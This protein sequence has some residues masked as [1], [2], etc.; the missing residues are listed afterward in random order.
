LQRTDPLPPASEEAV[1]SAL[2]GLRRWI[3]SQS[4]KGYDP[5]DGLNAAVPFGTF[6]KWPAIL[7]MQFLKRFPLN[8]RP[9]LGIRK[10]YNPKAMGLLLHAYSLLYSADQSPATMATMDFLFNWLRANRSKGFSGYAWGYNFDWAGKA[11]TVKA[12][13]P[14]AVVTGFVARGLRAYRQATG[15]RAADELLAG[16]AEFVLR[17]LHHRPIEGGR[18]ISYTPLAMDYC[19]NASLLG[20]EVLASAWPVTGDAAC[21]AAAREAVD[22]VCGRQKPSGRWN[23]SWD[24]TTGRERGQ[25]DFHQGYIIESIHEIGRLLQW[26]EPAHA[27]A[28]KRGL[29]YYYTEQFFRDGRS[30]WRLPVEW[31][32]EIHNQAQGIITFSRLASFDAAYRPFAGVIA[33]WTIRNMQS[34]GGY[35]YYRKYRAFTNRIPYMRWSQAWM[36]LALAHWLEANRAVETGRTPEPAARPG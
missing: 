31:P 6:G 24:E 13:V 30:K 8:L 10:E 23:Y 25:V 29:H 28:L 34:A 2:R 12:F 21:A 19:Y 20:A 4:F 1:R 27:E 16:A 35:F 26:P 9:L 36:L 5:Y 3:E 17:D 32:V 11:K 22:F 7:A 15:N 18:C 33:G 14:T